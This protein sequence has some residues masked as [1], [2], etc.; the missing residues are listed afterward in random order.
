LRSIARCSRRIWLSTTL[1]AAL[2]D[3]RY[4][5]RGLRRSSV[6]TAVAMLTLAICIGANAAIFTVMHR[7]LLAPLPYPEGNRIVRLDTPAA[8][9]P[10]RLS[11]VLRG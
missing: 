11:E 8:S 4:A 3:V 6:F 2:N 1:E 7:V 5:W 9:D 10:N